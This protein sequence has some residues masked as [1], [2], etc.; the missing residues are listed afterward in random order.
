MSWEEEQARFW[1]WITRP[2]D[3]QQ[4]ADQIAALLAPHRHL[5]QAEALS[6]YN[7]AYHQR[8]VE[9]SSAIFPVLYNTLGRTLYSQL[10][11]A[12]MGEHPPRNGP[13]NRVGDDLP[14]FLR[15]H[16]QF[17]DLPA[18]ADIAQLE[19]LLNSLFDVVDEAPYTLAML[20]RLPGQDWP[21]Q[22]WQ[23]KQDWTL[24]QTRFDLEAYWR[25]IQS[26]IQAGGEPGAADASITLLPN[27]D[28]RFPNLLVFRREQRMQFQSIRPAFGLFLEGIQRGET[29]ASLCSTLAE[30][31]PEQDIPALSLSL[32]LRAIELELLRAEAAPPA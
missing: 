32:L 26:H 2:Q 10:W 20:Q 6:I 31:F 8:L 30:S 22:R 13:I 12:Y 4:D 9:V 3:L 11:I 1:Q 23:A 27:L 29:L 7:N 28:P 24:L 16:P 5:S 18:V 21:T 19:C 15:G 17:R 14:A 25:E